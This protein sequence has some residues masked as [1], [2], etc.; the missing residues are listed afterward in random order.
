MK[1][2][3]KDIRFISLVNEFDILAQGIRTRIKGTNNLTLIPKREVSFATKKVTYR[4]IVCDIRPN[5]SETHRSRL[6]VCGNLLDFEG[7]LSTPTATGT[8]TNIMVDNII[9]TKKRKSFMFRYQKNI[10]KQST[11]RSQIYEYA[12]TYDP[13]INY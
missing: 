4:R 6:T 1:C 9:S 13:S 3:Y 8:T 10:F 11:P 12:Y 5:K 2:I 7:A